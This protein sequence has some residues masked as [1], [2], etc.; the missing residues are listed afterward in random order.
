MNEF[1]IG[2]FE[3]LICAGAVLTAGFI[4]VAALKSRS[5]QDKEIEG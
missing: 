5:R 1:V 3:L 4:L 2:Q